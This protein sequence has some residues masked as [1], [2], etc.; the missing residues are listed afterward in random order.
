MDGLIFRP[1]R[2]VEM[3]WVDSVVGCLKVVS[4]RELTSRMVL[5]DRSMAIIMGARTIVFLFV[6]KELWQISRLRLRPWSVSRIIDVWSQPN[7]RRTLFWIIL[8]DDFGLIE[9][10]SSC[11]ISYSNFSRE[12]ST[13]CYCSNSGLFATCTP[14][15]MSREARRCT[16][17]VMGNGYQQSLGLMFSWCEVSLSAKLISHTEFHLFGFVRFSIHDWFFDDD[18][19]TYGRSARLAHARRACASYSFLVDFENRNIPHKFGQTS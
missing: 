14:L 5:V 18:W 2:L 6:T 4:D 1:D 7:D 11:E 13:V 17:F 15:E 12:L 10:L 8:F 3:Y 9:S 19:R 16:R